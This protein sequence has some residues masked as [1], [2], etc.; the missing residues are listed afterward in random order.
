M[1]VKYFE[2]EQGFMSFKYDYHML[3][4]H[5]EMLKTKR[6]LLGSFALWLY[7]DTSAIIYEAL[8]RERERMPHSV[9]QQLCE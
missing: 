1:F 5:V 9:L 7:L 8:K 6:Y 4:S 2:D 3:V